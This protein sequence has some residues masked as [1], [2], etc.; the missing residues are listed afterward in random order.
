MI[1][2]KSTQSINSNQTK[3]LRKKVALRERSPHTNKSQKPLPSSSQKLKQ[4]QV[5][6]TKYQGKSGSSLPVEDGHIPISD[7]L[8]NLYPTTISVREGKLVA[9]GDIIVGD[10]K[11]I[12]DYKSGKKELK[13]AKP[14]L[15]P[16]G[17]IPY[18]IK[19]DILQVQKEALGNLFKEL[20]DETSIQFVQFNPSK[21]KHYV[22]F[23]AGEEHCLAQV[24]YLNDNSKVTLSPG[25]GYPEMCHEIFHVIGL[26]HEQNRFDRDNHV[27]ILW[28]NIEEDYWS[29]FEKF[30]EQ[31]YSGGFSEALG[32]FSFNT[33]MI[34]SSTNFSRNQDYSMVNIFGD[35]F[36]APEHATEVDYGR[37]KKLYAPLIN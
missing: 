20:K 21:H 17:I 12:N 23:L 8:G 5:L 32:P 2:R 11:F 13:V 34:Y 3:P 22:E 36:E 14:K 1:F 29:Q 33:I 16:K 37:A 28:E 27:K 4:P 18:I 30:P 7:E 25:C 10:A 35:G 26:F 19:E 24:G 9:Y 31:L 6:K 15:W